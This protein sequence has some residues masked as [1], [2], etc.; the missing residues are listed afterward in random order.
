MMRSILFAA[1]LMLVGCGPADR[2]EIKSNHSH[3]GP[4]YEITYNTETGKEKLYVY[5]SDLIIQE[6]E[7]ELQV[8]NHNTGYWDYIHSGW[9]LRHVN[10]KV[11]E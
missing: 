8:W 5:S 10:T 1:I 9:S 11:G 7:V 3:C 4:V 2:E 6:N